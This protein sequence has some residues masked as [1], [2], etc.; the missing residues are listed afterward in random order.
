MTK[1]RL[2]LIII[3]LI[4]LVGLAVLAVL[5][6]GGSK[7]STTTGPGLSAASITPGPALYQSRA[8]VRNVQY[9][10]PY[11]QGDVRFFTGTAFAFYSSASGNTGNLSREFILPAVETV[12][13]SQDSA[14]VRVDATKL[15]ELDEPS[16]YAT[17]NHLSTIPD[18]WLID[19][20]SGAFKPVPTGAG[21][22]QIVGVASRGGVANQY[23]SLSHAGSAWSLNSFDLGG[24][25]TKRVE[26]ANQ[27][28]SP[29][30]V[31]ANANGSVIAS[32]DGLQSIT[33]AGTV[34]TLVAAQATLS[35]A[36]ISLDGRFVTYIK[37]A[38]SRLHVI[39]LQ[40]NIDR[41]LNTVTTQDV[42]T[43]SG[44]I[45]YLT[46]T[47]KTSSD[48]QALNTFNITAYN[49]DTNQVTASAV[50]PNTQ[51]LGAATTLIV[52]PAANSY[53][54][55]GASHDMAF[56][57]ADQAKAYAY[58]GAAFVLF[59]K[60]ITVIDQGTLDYDIANNRL[61]IN[62]FIGSNVDPIAPAQAVIAAIRNMGIDPNQVPKTWT[63]NIDVD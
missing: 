46:S 4:V 59:A 24:Q 12:V 40:T 48:A 27:P 20:K 63:R 61:N 43:T 49:L 56:A 57:G 45:V 30:L 23:V 5:S 2:L 15:T 62:L 33:D 47:T 19:F 32:S 54:L 22:S 18:W 3:G 10:Q 52:L 31:G 41:E 53:Y 39:E 21:T 29:T 1:S 14:V 26:L 36:K 55:T 42:V 9:P 51:Q 16:R 8:L 34:T 11:G 35:N 7:S 44:N 38:N 13:W 25:I 17:A 60:T 6:L 58:E 50:A 28:K 37:T